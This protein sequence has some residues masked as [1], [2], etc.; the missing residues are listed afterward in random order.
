MGIDGN[1]CIGTAVIPAG[2]VGIVILDEGALVTSANLYLEHF[3]LDR[4]PFDQEPDAGIFFD[5]AGREKIA[6]NLLAEIEEGKPLIKLIGSEGAGK[7]LLCR[8]LEQRLAERDY[9]FMSLEHPIGSYQDLLRTVCRVLGTAEEEENDPEGGQPPDYPAIFN[10]HL[11]LIASQGKRLVLLIDEAENLFLATLE[12]LLRLVCESENYGSLQVLII[13][14]PELKANLDQLSVY[15][16][17]VNV[18][19]GYVL[20]PFSLE[21]TG[22]Y[23]RFRLRKAGIPGEKHREVFTPEAIDAIY[24]AAM[25]NLSL[26]NSLAET[27]MKKAC[28][29][30]RFQV[31]EELIQPEQTLEENVSLAFFQGFDF[32]KDN[33]WWLLAGPV[34]VWLILVLA[35]PESDSQQG[36]FIAER[37]LEMLEPE[38][39][40]LVPADPEIREIIESI[41]NGEEERESFQPGKEVDLPEPAAA[42][43]EPKEDPAPAEAVV[44]RQVVQQKDEPSPEDRSILVE[45]AVTK[46]PAPAEP[47]AVKKPEPEPRNADALFRERVRASA[48]WLAWAYRG[49]YT[50]QLMVLASDQAE[51]N[52][53]RILVDDK[54]YAIRDKLYI[55]RKVAPETIYVFYGNYPSMEKARQARNDMPP[56][57]KK[58]Q[59]YALSIQEALKKIED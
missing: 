26:T 42:G 24:Q 10:E 47:V 59:P 38:E 41:E 20:E 9:P 36:K 25:G 57:L 28:S 43:S 48:A 56:F 19:S 51:E 14:R 32:L 12:R 11:R 13:G 21:E 49:G 46:K 55:L 1:D 53:K 23:M 6:G 4:D 52:L 40:I 8:L 31:D 54:Y 5:A 34:L 16:S 39:E 7:T 58:N 18:A 3:Q 45:P 2:E 44:T 35:W 15:C 50:V 37:Q 33:K 30:G 27:G 29:L 22:E 17:N